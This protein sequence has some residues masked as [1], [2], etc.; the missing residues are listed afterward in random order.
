MDT[1]LIA[2]CAALSAISVILVIICLVTVFKLK[3]L[4]NEN[5]S[6]KK[7]D[8]TRRELENRLDS[9]Q[10]NV[11]A[12]INESLRTNSQIQQQS[13]SS[14]GEQISLVSKGI[15]SRMAELRTS[16]DTRLE[17]VR[18]SVSDSIKQLQEDNRKQLEE[19]RLSVD[20]K[21]QKTL[22]ERVSESFKLVGNQL[23]Q[24]HK[25]LGEMQSLASGVGD[26]KKILSNVKTRGIFGE[27]QLSRILEQILTPEQ[28]VTNFATKA[29]SRDVVEF[30]VKLPGKGEYDEPVYLPIDA[31]FPLDVYNALLD[32]Y[33]TSDNVQIE[34]AAKA[35][36][37]II[38]KNA[39]D[40]H[41]KYI[42]PPN[43]TDFAIMFLPTES[44][45]AEV[46]R[47]PGLL[48]TIARDYSINIAGPTTISALLNSLQMGFRTLAIEKRSHEVWNLLGAIKTEFGNFESA[49]Q[50][51]KK[52]FDSADSELN[53]LM[54]T[55]TRAVLRKLKSVEA[56]PEAEA[57]KVLGLDS[58][59]IFDD[60]VS[61]EDN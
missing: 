25:S 5:D 53:K 54:T 22:N 60:S 43:T 33:D 26:L 28:Y 8:D 2:V 1:I 47:R 3:N 15:D 40:I 18:N 20:E 31:K 41:D 48:E 29:G 21:L 14:F 35:L 12:V 51:V 52:R 7:L 55:R 37:T 6:E 49:L 46:V 61:P 11:T 59:E 45:Y 16:Q 32:A 24:V 30:A 34:H 57:T 4:K 13:L 39:K 9:V 17:A 56:M 36:E 19:I 38:K 10:R 23:E 27:M 50:M 44:L 42:D 58:D